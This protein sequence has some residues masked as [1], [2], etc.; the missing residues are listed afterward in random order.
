M[1]SCPTCGGAYITVEGARSICPCELK[2]KCK[3]CREPANQAVVDLE[4]DVRWFTCAKHG[5]IDGEG[6]QRPK[7]AVAKPLP[8]KPA[9]P[10][11]P[12]P[13]PVPRPPP[14]P[15]APRRDLRDLNE[16]RIEVSES[17][18][19]AECRRCHRRLPF[20]Q[21]VCSL[22]EYKL[23]R[24]ACPSCGGSPNFLPKDFTP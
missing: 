13:K 1:T 10:P 22:D 9:P 14:K 24:A 23:P 15:Q 5:A 21:Y 17:D 3:R 11:P 16:F 7:A 8:P 20:K 18:A 4:G 2:Q 19:F 12:A 6:L